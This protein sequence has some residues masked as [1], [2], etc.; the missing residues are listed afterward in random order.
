ML[1]EE[2]RV[3]E[4][5]FLKSVVLPMRKVWR[6]KQRLQRCRQETNLSDGQSNCCRRRVLPLLLILCILVQLL[7]FWH[8]TRQT[9]AYFAVSTNES[10]AVSSKAAF[11]D[12]KQLEE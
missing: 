11:F 2:S 5:G 12:C 7:I 9:H 3:P 1:L 10:S 6:C 4:D 8:V